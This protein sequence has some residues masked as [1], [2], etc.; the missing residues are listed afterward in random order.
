LVLCDLSNYIGN[1]AHRLQNEGATRVPEVAAAQ[2]WFLAGF[3]AQFTPRP[4]RPSAA[5]RKPNS[6]ISWLPTRQGGAAWRR[7]AS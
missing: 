1:P 4:S 6:W 2:L 7:R 3:Y 5:V